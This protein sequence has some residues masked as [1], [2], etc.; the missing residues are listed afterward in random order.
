MWWAVWVASHVC[1]SW[2]EPSISRIYWSSQFVVTLWIDM[3]LHL[4]FPQN[5]AHLVSFDWL[6]VNF[7]GKHV[8]SCA[9]LLP[10]HPLK[11]DWDHTTNVPYILDFEMLQRVILIDP[12]KTGRHRTIIPCWCL[13]RITEIYICQTYRW[14]LTSITDINCQIT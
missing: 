6:Q 10:N 7:T 3:L 14:N 8:M 5:E 11:M 1:F 4:L 13:S 12:M 9:H 2:R